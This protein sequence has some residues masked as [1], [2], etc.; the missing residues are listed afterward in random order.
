VVVER[1][2]I[3]VRAGLR[4]LRERIALEGRSVAE[5]ERLAHEAFDEEF[6]QRLP[7]DARA[8]TQAEQDE[9]LGYRP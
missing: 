8:P 2:A 5:R 6:L 9:I 3:A 4:E 7:K 1:A